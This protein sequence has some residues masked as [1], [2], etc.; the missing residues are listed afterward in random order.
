M[1]YMFIYFF[2]I[3]YKEIE[4]Q[5]LPCPVFASRKASD[6]LECAKLLDQGHVVGIPTDTVYALG[7]SCKHPESINAIYHI[8]GRPPEKPI[9]LCISSLDQLKTANPPFR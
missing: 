7:A 4:K 2:P 8:K 9:C 5:H 3:Q 1:I 6:I